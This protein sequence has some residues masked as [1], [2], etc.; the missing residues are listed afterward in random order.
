MVK[1][2]DIYLVNLDDEVSKDAKNSR[3]SVVVSPDEMN[4][5]VPYVIVAPISSGSAAYPTRIPIDLLRSKRHIVLDQ[6][7]A[8]DSERLVKQIGSLD[9]ATRKAVLE[10][11]QEF[12]AE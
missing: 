1:R 7:R 5:N 11:L 4:D 10:T 2:F 3:P 6:M 9:A 8:V 12:F